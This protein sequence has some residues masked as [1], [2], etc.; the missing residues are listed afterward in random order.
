MRWLALSL[1]VFVLVVLPLVSARD[2]WVDNSCQVN[3]NGNTQTCGSNGP[4]HDLHDALAAVQPGDTVLIKNGTGAY[5]TNNVGVPWDDGRHRPH[6]GGGFHLS[7]PPGGEP[8]RITSAPGHFPLIANCAANDFETF[9]PVPTFSTGGGGRIIFDRLHIQG[10]II[11]RSAVSVINSR[12][13]KGYE[14]EG[15][16]NLGVIKIIHG[17]NWDVGPIRNNYFHDLYAPNNPYTKTWIYVFHSENLLIE[18]NTFE[19][20]EAPRGAGAYLDKHSHSINLTFRYNLIINGR[21]G[22][23][24][25][26]AQIHAYGNVIHCG[27]QPP[28]D[29]SRLQAGSGDGLEISGGVQRHNTVVNC[30]AGYY[31]HPEDSERYPEREGTRAGQLYNN[32]FNNIYEGIQRI[33]EP[34]SP[35]QP[36]DYFTGLEHID[37]NAYTPNRRFFWT[38]AHYGQTWSEWRDGVAADFGFDEN[39]AELECAFRDPANHDYRLVPGSACTTFGRVG[40]VSSGAPIE[41]GA[42]GVTACVGHLCGPGSGF[43]PYDSSWRTAVG[44]EVPAPVVG[45]CGSRATTFSHDVSSWPSGSSYCSSGSASSQPGFPDAGQSVSW[46]CVGAGGTVSCAAERESMPSRPADVDEDGVVGFSDL[47]LVVENLG[48]LPSH[49][50]F[51]VRADVNGDGVVDLFDLVLV[52]LAFGS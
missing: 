39:S 15:D 9:C 21:G 51:V 46:Q 17:A 29:P 18:Y 45:S 52:A 24:G 34:H 42:F 3:G 13:S 2:I 22:P 37:F 49:P 26:D 11:I 23:K 38:F 36:S 40:G 33:W 19:G 48:R 31:V 20:W 32:I 35:L 1:M 16:G 10:G 27:D 6:V 50:D 25:A 43:V 12:L 41:L 14:P 8:V 30:R 4:F 28:S 44:Q 7:V 47:L 5:V